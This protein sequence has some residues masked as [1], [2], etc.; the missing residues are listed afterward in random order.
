MELPS[1]RLRLHLGSFDDRLGPLDA[2]DLQDLS[3]PLEIFEL[4]SAQD[5]LKQSNTS[6]EKSIISSGALLSWDD[7]AHSSYDDPDR[8]CY[9]ANPTT[10]RSVYLSEASSHVFDAALR[11]NACQSIEK[12][13]LS[14]AVTRDTLVLCL[15]YLGLGRD[16]LLFVYHDVKGSFVYSVERLAISGLSESVVQSACT[17]MI[18]HG[19]N[20]KALQRFVDHTYASS[21]SLQGKISLAACISSALG[22]FQSSLQH[23]AAMAPGILG[24]LNDF[25][26]PGQILRCLLQVVVDAERT[27]TDEHLL[28]SLYDRVLQLDDTSYW[29]R[30]TLLEIISCI[31]KPWLEFTSAWIGLTANSVNLFSES[32]G[33]KSFVSVQTVQPVDSFRQTTK[34]PEF[35][36]DESKMPTFISPEERSRIFEAGKSLRYLAKLHPSHPLVRP[37]VVSTVLTPTLDWQFSWPD[38]EWVE[39]KA[40]AYGESLAAAIET[41]ETC[42]SQIQAAEVMQHNLSLSPVRLFEKTEVEIDQYLTDSEST[43]DRPLED[44]QEF[45]QSRFHSILLNTFELERG[46]STFEQSMFPPP[47]SLM[48]LLSFSPII[49]TRARLIDSSCIRLFFRDHDLRHHLALQRQFHLFGNGVFSSKLSSALFSPELQMAQRQKGVARGGSAMGLQLENRDSWPPASSELRLALMDVLPDSYESAFNVHDPDRQKTKGSGDLPGGL[50]FAVRELSPEELHKCKNTDSL[51]AMDFL[52]LQYRPP[53]PLDAIITPTSLYKYD[54]VFKLILRT[55]RMMHIVHQLFL[56]ASSRHSPRATSQIAHRFRI[57]ATHFV[58]TLTAYFLDAAIAQ[59]WTRFESAMDRIEQHLDEDDNTQRRIGT[60]TGHGGGGVAHIRHLHEQTLDQITFGLLL[61]R[62]QEPV[63]RVLESIFSAVM[64]FS[65]W[66]RDHAPGDG[67]DAEK[68]ARLYASF[69]KRV[70]LFVGICR[71]LAEKRGYSATTGP[72]DDVLKVGGVGVSG[73]IIAQLCVKLE[74]NGYYSDV[75]AVDKD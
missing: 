56:S 54:L 73:N 29:L 51:S 70:R 36:L 71:G 8:Y 66:S 59:P 12:C 69:R 43:L 64:Q 15:R 16:S 23:R 4:P 46:P 30:D 7:F 28:S 25:E 68:V 55:S 2:F 57:D 3:L 14:N 74:M 47:I 6:R 32:S 45:S 34:D 44:P 49:A 19:N 50:G 26:R 24:V 42:K 10:L 38:V 31:S 39:A 67:G 18:Q 9:S 52:S 5:D 61:R 72:N 17:Q 13:L 60:G 1:D 53:P 22:V 40:K 33:S 11:L 62:R 41:F 37:D 75:V 20:I 21:N 48:P 58:T 63:R 27:S 35:I 65:R